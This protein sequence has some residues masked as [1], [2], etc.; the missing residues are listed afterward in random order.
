MGGSTWRYPL[1][2]HLSIRCFGIYDTVSN[3]ILAYVYDESEGGKV[4]NNEASFILQYVCEQYVETNLGPMLELN[5]IMDNYVGKNM[6]YMVIRM[7]V[8]RLKLKYF[9][10]VNLIFWV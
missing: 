8:Y 10:K 6:N 4:W 7:A 2:F 3:H 9:K 1:F 5:V